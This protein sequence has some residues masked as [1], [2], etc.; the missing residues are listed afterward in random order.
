MRYD[1]TLAEYLLKLQSDEQ[2][3]REKMGGKKGVGRDEIDMQT[4]FREKSLIQNA[5]I[6]AG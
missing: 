2:E 3:Q 4:K 5:K 1:P 6:S